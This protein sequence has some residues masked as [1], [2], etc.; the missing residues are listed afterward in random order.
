[1]A[2]SQQQ[3]DGRERPP[4]LTA[5]LFGG[6]LLAVDGRVVDTSSSRRTRNLLAYLVTYR[7]SPVPRDVLMDVFWPDSDPEAARNSLHVA[8]SGVRQALR[9]V[10]SHPLLHRRFDTYQL[11]P[12][13]TAWVDVSE[14]D[15][16][17]RRAQ[18]LE[19]A[20]D[21]AGARRAFEVAADLY[22]GDFLA[23]DPYGRW[24]QRV[25]EAL[26]L[27]VTELRT[28]L[29]ALQLE[30]G[31]VTAATTTAR[32]ALALD[33]CNELLHRQLMACYAASGQ[34]HRALAQYVVCVDTLW[35]ELRVRPGPDTDRLY[36]E[37][38]GRSGVDV[39]MPGTV[40]GRGWRAPAQR[41]VAP[42]GLALRV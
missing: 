37:L 29:V 35:G 26:R 10:T 15:R 30:A 28:R 25:R 39:R 11:A 38:C 24:P 18:Q 41:L 13:A 5:R 21:A 20:G 8:L 23:D 9:E 34:Q 14:F 1:M 27:Q 22:D 17:C 12:A 42:G 16:A 31:D 33:P 3:A 6:F 32:A 4:M 19:R 36:S 40:G 2:W 7:H